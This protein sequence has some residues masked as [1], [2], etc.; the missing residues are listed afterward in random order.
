MNH[1]AQLGLL[2]F[3]GVAQLKAFEISRQPMTEGSGA[4]AQLLIPLRVP[5]FGGDKIGAQGPKDQFPIA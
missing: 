4:I 3:Q 5:R 2:L 1:G